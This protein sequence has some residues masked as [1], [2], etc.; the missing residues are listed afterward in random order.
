[1]PFFHE[2]L[3][4]CEKSSRE[5]GK[6]KERITGIPLRNKLWK[7]LVRHA[8]GSRVGL[9][10]NSILRALPFLLNRI[11]PRSQDMTTH[12]QN[13]AK[14]V[15]IPWENGASWII[16]LCHIAGVFPATAGNIVKTMTSNRRQ[17]TVTRE[18]LTAVVRHLSITWLFVFHRFDPLALL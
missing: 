11:A 8:L 3:I 17:F 10:V 7:R 6:R 13:R 4:L 5:R 16:S 18:M 14:P 2:I 9:S 1:M 15:F 12:G